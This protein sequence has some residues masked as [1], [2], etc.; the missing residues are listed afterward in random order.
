MTDVAVMGISLML[1]Q[2]ITMAFLAGRYYY[3]YFIDGKE[4]S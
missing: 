3:S 4:V 2:L 1:W